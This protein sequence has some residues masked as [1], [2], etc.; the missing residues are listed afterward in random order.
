MKKNYFLQFE[1]K[2]FKFLTPAPTSRD[3]LTEKTSFL[4]QIFNTE[5][6]KKTGRGEISWISGLSIDDEEKI[7]L[8][9]QKFAKEGICETDLK[10]L[11][12]DLP[13][14]QMGLEM[15]FC[16]LKHFSQN[17]YFPSAFTD[18][19]MALKING[20]IWMGEKSAVQKQIQNKIDLGFHC[21][22]M[23]ISKKK[24]NEELNIIQWLRQSFAPKELLLRLDA[25]GAFAADE[26][27][28]ILEKLA[29]FSIEYLEQALPVGDPYWQTCI[30]NSPIPLALDEELIGKSLFEI[31]HLIHTW[32]PPYLVIKPSLL[33]GF[34]KSLQ[35]LH[36]AAEHNCK[37]RITSALEGNIGLNALAQFTAKYADPQAYHGLGTGQL[38]AN[39]TPSALDLRGDRMRFLNEINTK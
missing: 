1:K 22:K 19:K 33:G 30:K 14:L 13:A 10:D 11:P 29:P 5:D 18:Q 32:Q 37:V 17:I 2:I 39:N 36:L 24:F 27:D 23:K 12:D 25:N 38:Y 4:V 7:A 15:A 28:A 9:L 3:I 34:N 6:P 31:K 16:E 35:I 21:I 8:Y 20:L 26:V